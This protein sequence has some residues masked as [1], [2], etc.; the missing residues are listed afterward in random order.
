MTA[1][2]CVKPVAPSGLQAVLDLYGD[3]RV[4]VRADGSL[5]PQWEREFTTLVQIP[6]RPVLSWDKSVAISSIRC[7]VKIADHVRHT[8]RR[9]H[10]LGLSESL[11][12]YGGGFAWRS[13]RGDT[14]KPSLHAWAAA[15]DWNPTENPRGSRP[16]IDRKVV[17]VFEEHG[18]LWGGR[19]PGKRVD[20]MH[21][22]F[23]FSL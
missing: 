17:A 23:A 11:T 6:W 1:C 16:R 18:F 3:P 20:G 15:W 4:F 8:M 14:T 10:A 2:P 19:W 21:F 9:V 5:A 7:H 22:Q 13:Q 12:E